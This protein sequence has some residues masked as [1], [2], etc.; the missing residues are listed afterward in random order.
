[1]ETTE[2]RATIKLVKTAD[3]NNWHADLFQFVTDLGDFYFLSW[4]SA[5]HS[6]K[7]K[8]LDTYPEKAEKAFKDIVMKLAREHA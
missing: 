6:L 7:Q 8:I 1:M 4:E 2:Y 3:I 5:G